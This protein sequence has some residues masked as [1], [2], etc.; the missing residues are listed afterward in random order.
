MFILTC[1]YHSPS[2]SHNEFENFC[3]KFDILLGQ[4]NDELPICS[5]M[6]GDFNALDAQDGGE[7]TS[8][9]LQGKK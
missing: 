1:L 2:Q 6:T 3:I 5:V 8:Q 4:I 7:M 9:T